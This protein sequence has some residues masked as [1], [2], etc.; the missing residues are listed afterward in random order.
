MEIAEILQELQ[1]ELGM[2]KS[3]YPRWVEQKK[4]TQKTADFRIAA[5]EQAIVRL[6]E[7]Q[8]AEEAA[9]PVQ[10]NLFD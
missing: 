5:I 8:A 4:L 7:L 6:Q 10:A 2:R 9:K 3:V 1:R